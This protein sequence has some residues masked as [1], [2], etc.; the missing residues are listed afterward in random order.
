VKLLA[1]FVLA[2]L[3]GSAG[4]A[5]SI[6]WSS[7]IGATNYLSDGETP[8]GGEFEFLLGTFVGIS[9]G[10]GNIDLWEDS[11][12][13]FGEAGYSEGLSRFSNARSLTSN[14]PPFTTN[15]QI[16]IWGR[17]GTVS[18]SE[19]ILIS[20]S[21]WKWPNANPGGP[22]PFPVRFL[23][24]GTSGEDAILGSVNEGGVHMQTEKVEIVLTYD[25]WATEQFSEGEPSG[26]DLDFD[27]D[28]RSNFLEYA[29]GSDPKIKDEPFR[30]ALKPDFTFE[31]TRA[32]GRSVKWVVEG[33]DDLVGFEALE[34]GV[35]V[36]IDTP[37]RLGYKIT[38]IS[39]EKKFFRIKAEPV[40]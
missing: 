12:V 18:G 15:D 21:T 24:A 26:A 8:L 33:S 38:D 13:T 3:I 2:L 5:I 22:P 10:T 29:L 39:A 34:D 9:P 35:E 16:Y 28:G 19:W 40:N 37:T 4:G 14:A 6:E 7:D 1:S 27:E 23:V 31:F 25:A 17:N 11:W 30:F 36:R 20:K 32:E